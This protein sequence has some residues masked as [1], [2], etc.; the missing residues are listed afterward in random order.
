MKK[1]VSVFVFLS[2]F[3]CISALIAK[4]K[5]ETDSLKDISLSGLSFWKK[6][7]EYGTERIRTYWRNCS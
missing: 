2:L 3:S 1:L 7:E 5:S 4:D 6:L